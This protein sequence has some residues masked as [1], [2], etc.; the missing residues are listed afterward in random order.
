ML[1]NRVSKSLLF[2]LAA[3]SLPMACAAW[4]P[5]PGDVSVEIVGDDG[6]VL[7]QFDVS[8]ADEPGAGR[9]YLEAVKGKRYGIRIR[10]HRADRIGL[11]IAVDGRNIISG[12]KS[13][14]RRNEPMYLLN[15]YQTATYDGWR[16]SDTEVHRFYFT[17]TD[18]SYADAFGDRTAMGVISVA[19]YAEKPRPRQK[20]MYREESREDTGRRAAPSAALGE[21]AKS[22]PAEQADAQ[23]GT[24]FGEGVTSRV[25]RVSFEPSYQPFAKRFLKY[26]WRDTLVRMGFIRGPAPANRFWPEH[27]G[28]ASGKGYAP[29]PP[30]HRPP[31]RRW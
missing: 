25:V 30:G 9:A 29:Y 20:R 21:S 10:N 24:G 2:I 1:T 15:P 19:A 16:T 7:R 13:H 14:L 12:N 23:P 28:Q 4:Q 18:D 3:V 11:V 6:R 31:S 26:E 17:R 8:R 22:A 27:V 5:G